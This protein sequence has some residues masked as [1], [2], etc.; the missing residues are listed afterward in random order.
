MSTASIQVDYN[1]DLHALA[2]T[3]AAV[4]RPGDF[5][6][7][8]SIE[9]P[10]PRLDIEGVGTVSFP[11]PAAQAR[12]IIRQAVRADRGHHEGRPRR[13]ARARACQRRS[14]GWHAHLRPRSRDAVAAHRRISAGAQR[15]SARTAKRHGLD[16]THVTDRRGS[17]QT[18]VCTKTRRTYRTRREEYRRDIGHLRT[19]EPLLAQPSTGEQALLTR[20]RAA[21]ASRT[22]S[23]SF[24]T[25]H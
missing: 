11:I 3:L 16:M 19:L 8:G 17:P 13:P 1:R 12:Q 22:S 4:E 24:I 5:C 25:P 14:P 10:M 18:L 20:I 7:F 23:N 9:A 15:R 2:E 21:V 6:A